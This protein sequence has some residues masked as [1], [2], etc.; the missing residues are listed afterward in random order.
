MDTINTLKRA[1]VFLGLDD[2]ELE[3]IASLSSCREETY[4]PEDVIFKSKNQAKDLYIVSDGQ[5]ELVVRNTRASGETEKEVVV[6]RVSKGGL[7]GWSSLVKPH[8]YTL[9]AVCRKQTRLLVINGSELQELFQ[10]NI[11]IGFKVYQSLSQ[12]IG[13]RLRYMEQ[14]IATTRKWPFIEDKKS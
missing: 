9:T 11:E 4:Q 8:Y 12:I 5:V 2:N 6:D 3:R 13:N 1:E 14:S 7:F 10:N